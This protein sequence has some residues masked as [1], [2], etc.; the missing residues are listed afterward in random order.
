MASKLSLFFILIGSAASA[1]K[2]PNKQVVS[3]RA[4]INIKIDGKASEWGD[5]L[6][7]HNKATEVLYTIANDDENLY[8]VIQATKRD[9]VEKIAYGGIT[10]SINS[11]DKKENVALTFPKYESNSSY[12]AGLN[13]K[14]D[15]ASDTILY[16]MQLDSFVRAKNNQMGI[17]FKFIEVEGIKD[18]GPLISVY[19]DVKIKANIRLDNQ[20]S[21][22]YELAIPL[23]YLS[24]VINSFGGF[25][26]NIRLNGAANN[27][28]T[29]ALNSTGK[30]IIIYDASGKA[31]TGIPVMYEASA[32]KMGLSYPTDFTAEYTLAKK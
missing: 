12:H 31:V 8:L 3:V 10:F 17:K 7:A 19:N 13:S 2:L 22:T 27:H 11:A 1:Q 21:Y 20:L 16:K 26:Y 25:T 29:M 9:I 30:D 24:S 5:K 6:Q 32:A 18:M 28:T 14:P 4:P 15:I 23:K